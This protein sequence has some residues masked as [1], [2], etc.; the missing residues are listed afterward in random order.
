MEA[1]EETRVKRVSGDTHIHSAQGI[2]TLTLSAPA[3]C[4]HIRGQGYG[5]VYIIPHS[6]PLV[7]H[8][9]HAYI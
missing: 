5:P 4:V 1:I 6:P 8:F 7:S 9:Y 3:S 2:V